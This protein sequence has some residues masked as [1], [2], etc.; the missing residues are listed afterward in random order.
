MTAAASIDC[1]VIGAGPAGS[2]AARELAARDARVLLVDRA[3]FP[4]D[5]PCGGGVLISAA[6][7]LPFSLDPV[8]ERVVE[9]FHVTY[10]RRGTFRH[11]FGAPLAYMTQRARLDA[12]LVER[13][14][15]TGVEFQD[16][17]AIESVQF[18]GD[19]VV[20]RFRGGDQLTAR[21]AV[22]ADGANSVVRRSFRLPPFRSAVALEAN[23][24]IDV[25]ADIDSIGHPWRDQI[26]L[27]LG[28]I[29]GG[30]GWVFPK[31]DHLNV[32]VG[33]WPSA[34]PTLRRELDRYAR[35]LGFDPAALHDRR[36]HH[37]PL[38]DPDSVLRRGPIAFVGDAA[39][40]VD[41]LSGEGIGNAFHS[42]RLAA[43]EIDRL[44]RGEVTDLSG[45]EQAV[46]REIEPDLAVSRQLQTIFHQAPWVYTQLLQRS[47][48]F[49]RAFCHIVRG[50][51][52][53]TRFKNRLGP[54]ALVLNAAAWQARRTTARRSGWQ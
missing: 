21:T 52:N 48:R 35:S 11:Q 54:L 36:G 38:R 47:G 39:G 24:D 49:W 14:C 4:R 23:L 51:S 20:V 3:Q 29:P 44:L 40:L 41:P 10:R 28:S 25:E 17:R 31:G 42:G 8:I 32:G 12:Y 19:G 34:G 45:Y 15:E 6:A 16:G 9:T 27:D 43:F 22:A 18:D 1:I 30:Y 7:Q 53:Y 37:L 2:T 5:K 26:A 46:R 13:A 50:E 33:G